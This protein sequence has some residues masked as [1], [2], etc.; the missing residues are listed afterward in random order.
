MKLPGT[1]CSS[2]IAAGAATQTLPVRCWR[3]KRASRVP[4]SHHVSVP[5]GPNAMAGRAK[6]RTTFLPGYRAFRL[7][8]DGG[9]AAAAGGGGAAEARGA[10]AERKGA[11]A[12]PTEPGAVRAP[13]PPPADRT[14]SVTSARGCFVW[15]CLSCAPTFCG[16]GSSAQSTAVAALAALVPAQQRWLSLAAEPANSVVCCP[17]RQQLSAFPPLSPSG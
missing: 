1:Q 3:I 15:R 8:K 9:D 2:V 7:G 10:G 12:V 14:L 17:T 11:A 5:F 4:E 16:G 6:L 13:L